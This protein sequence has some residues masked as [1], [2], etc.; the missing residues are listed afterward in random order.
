MRNVSTLSFVF[1]NTN[2]HMYLAF[3]VYAMLMKIFIKGRNVNAKKWV[4][5]GKTV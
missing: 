3:T 1:D 5:E 4:G 2:M